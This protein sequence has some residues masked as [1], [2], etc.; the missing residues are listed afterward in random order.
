MAESGLE[1]KA[2]RLAVLPLDLLDA[3]P[4][5]REVFREP[6]PDEVADLAGSIAQVGLIHPLKVRPK[7][8]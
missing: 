7:P 1:E 4:A 6:T 5:N 2:S 3:H 8:D